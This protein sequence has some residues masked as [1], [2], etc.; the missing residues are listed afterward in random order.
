M[1]L[2]VY[3]LCHS[4]LPLIFLYQQANIPYNMLNH[5]VKGEESLG[6]K[7]GLKMKTNSLK[8]GLLSFYMGHEPLS[9]SHLPNISKAPQMPTDKDMKKNPPSCHILSFL[10]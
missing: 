9:S 4:H 2:P 6:R 5:P 7:Q 1:I 10:L 8:M 3:H